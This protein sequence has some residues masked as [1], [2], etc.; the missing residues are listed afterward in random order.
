MAP[1]QQQATRRLQYPLIKEDTLNYGSIPNIKEWLN[2]S[3]IPNIKVYS[4]IKGYWSLWEPETLAP[5]P[6]SS[7]SP[8]KPPRRSLKT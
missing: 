5:N 6:K 1:E 8:A 2:Y 3:S 4:L 7:A